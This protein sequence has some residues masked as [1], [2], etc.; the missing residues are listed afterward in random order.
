MIH[1]ILEI[2]RKLL[3]CQNRSRRSA[4]RVTIAGLTIKSIRERIM[5]TRSAVLALLVLALS[6]LMGQAG[7]ADSQASAKGYPLRPVTII[8]PATGGA[9]D[10]IARIVAAALARSFNSPVIVEARPGAGG[11]IAT[12]TVAHASA[13]GYTL[14][15]ALN[16]MLTINPVLY[17]SIRF[18]P[19]EDFEPVALVATSRYLLAINSDVKANTVREL[20][21]E[22]KANPNKISYSSSGYG[23]P[24][25]LMG[26]LFGADTGAQFQHVPYRSMA[27]ATTDLLSGQV[28]F[29]CGSMSGL[30]PQ[31][32]AGKL[33]ALGVTG[34]TR[35]PL[36]PDIP[37]IA[38]TVPGFEFEAWYALLAP[39]HTPP[40]I[41]ETLG[42]ALRSALASDGTRERL[43][44]QGAD[45]SSGDAKELK[46]RIR[47]DLQKWTKMIAVLGLHMD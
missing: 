9:S 36:A 27:N 10:T 29:M 34:Q 26:A 28:Q 16:N 22:A 31:V 46:G 37:T 13:D 12:E 35:S 32:R 17:R 44:Q 43:L 8:S 38:E 1:D 39:A 25:H 41:V 7:A 45:A 40:E 4:I 20:I 47:D 2:V 18:N 14:L 21:E 5:R 11:N 42:A 33:K 19:V 3:F 30:M 24:S 15:L 6:Q 23:T